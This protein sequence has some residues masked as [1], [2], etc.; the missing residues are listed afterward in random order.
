MNDF[1]E[2][3]EKALELIAD[4]GT[5]RIRHLREK[6]RGAEIERLL[7]EA[8]TE[9]RDRDERIDFLKSSLA[10][11]QQTYSEHVSTIAA[12]KIENAKLRQLYY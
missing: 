9:V 4:G 10:A 5:M 8:I 3:A 12:L 1:I 6:K 2:R 11:L 7:R